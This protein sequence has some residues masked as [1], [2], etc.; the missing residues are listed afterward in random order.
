MNIPDQDV[1]SMMNQTSEVLSDTI[2]LG[3]AMM[4]EFS[5]QGESLEKAKTHTESI[6]KQAEQ[7]K[8]II[9]SMRSTPYALWRWFIDTFQWMVSG[10]FVYASPAS[11]I[12]SNT[13]L[14]T[15]FKSHETHTHT[16]KTTLEAQV[17]TL[18]AQAHAM[19]EALDMHLHLLDEI[20]KKVDTGCIQLQ[21]CD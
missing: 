11:E 20:N 13:C 16:T 3:E 21:Q 8:H 12:V 18:H 4:V 15:S 6:V 7:A 2:R 5:N 9:R 17:I 19:N 14:N 10:Q 1:E